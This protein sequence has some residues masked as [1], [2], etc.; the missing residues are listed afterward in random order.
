M[1]PLQLLSLQKMHRP[2]YRNLPSF[3]PTSSAI[4]QQIK[5]Y[6]V[7]NSIDL[8]D[9]KTKELKTRIAE[10]FNTTQSALKTKN[11]KLNELL[12]FIIKHFKEVNNA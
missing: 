1:K 5:T 11:Q 3:N 12:Q 9:R 6:C 10:K 8:D 2:S 7:I 4:I